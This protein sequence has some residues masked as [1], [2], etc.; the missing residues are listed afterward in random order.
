MDKELHE[1]IADVFGGTDQE[2]IKRMDELERLFV[3]KGDGAAR[4]QLSKRKPREQTV[5]IKDLAK[6]LSY[7]H[8]N[9]P[10]DEMYPILK[11][12]IELMIEHLVKEEDIHLNKLGIF[13]TVFM[14]TWKSNVPGKKGKDKRMHHHFAP[15]FRAFKEVKDRTYW[16]YDKK[17]HEDT[18]LLDKIE[19]LKEKSP[20]SDIDCVETEL[21]RMKNEFLKSLAH[22]RMLK[23]RWDDATENLK[24]DEDS[25]Q[26]DQY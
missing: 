12:M 1:E 21:E 6:E 17:A 24:D 13:R 9:V 10:L 18:E 4:F 23:D 19:E 7:L 22:T 8:P 25:S 15:T 3:E 16:G 26:V 2:N 20:I 5:F 14:R 11:D